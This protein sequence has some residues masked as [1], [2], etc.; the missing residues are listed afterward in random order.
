MAGVQPEASAKPNQD[1][2]VPGVPDEDLWLLIRRFNKQIYNVQAT[3]EPR[4]GDLDLNPVQDEQFPPEKVRIT[5]ERLYVSVIVGLIT[6]YTHVVRLRSWNEPRRTSA[7]CATYFVAWF[8]GILVPTISLFLAALI[9]FPSLRPLLFPSLTPEDN[10]PKTQPQQATDQPSK[11]KGE[12]AEQEANSLMNSIAKIA[13]K[14]AT[15][16]HGQEITGDSLEET[17]ASDS[18]TDVNTIPDAAV[19]GD[20]T[21]RS[22]RKAVA[23]AT[24]QAMRVISDGTDIYEMFSNVLSPTP[25][26]TYVTAQIQLVGVLLLI[27]LLTSIVSN[28]FIVRANSFTLGFIFFGGPM[29]QYSMN[30]LNEKFPDWKKFLDPRETILKNIPTNAQLTLTLLRLCETNNTPLPSPPSSLQPHSN[31][32]IPSWITYKDKLKITATAA[33]AASSTSLTTTATATTTTSTSTS[34]PSTSKRRRFLPRL[35]RILRTTITLATKGHSAFNQAM[36]IAGA[37]QG[38]RRLLLT[39]HRRN[40]EWETSGPDTFDAKFERKRGTLVID[41]S[42][43]PSSSFIPPENEP[44]TAQLEEEEKGE[45]LNPSP[46][47]YFSTLHSATLEDRRLEHQKKGTVLFQIP[48][49]QIRGLRKTEGLGW[50]GKLIVELAAGSKESVDGLV[51]CGAEEGQTYHVTG[52]KARD[53]LFNRLVAMG[54]QAWERA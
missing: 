53:Q 36:A 48:I 30:Y 46:I 3:S 43:S 21:K 18:T 29:H 33:A 8:R 1:D 19:T 15:S 34:E 50:K 28:D 5:L 49:S 52:M 42:P 24:T 51:I 2:L 11:H 37:T 4:A 12:A 16:R 9:L 44:S 39:M 13:V 17:L 38:T 27:C 6:L 35:L 32:P 26:F 54:G 7:F 20:D 41:S 23:N 47:L 31:N 14:A 10:G 45:S 22:M 40:W 25:P